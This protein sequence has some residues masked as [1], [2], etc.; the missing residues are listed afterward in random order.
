MNI[1][2]SI[3]SRTLV[4]WVLCTLIA[5][6]AVAGRYELIKRDVPGESYQYSDIP[7]GVCEAYEKN[8]NR[9]SDRPNGMAC[10]REIDPELGFTRPKWERLD[11]LKYKELAKDIGR[12]QG[13]CPKPP[14]GQSV[15]PKC[16][17]GVFARMI[18]NGFFLELTHLDI[19][20]DG[21]P[22]TVVRTGRD[23]PCDPNVESNF[24]HPPYESLYVADAGLTRVLD[25]SR[26]IDQ[27]GGDI[28]RYRGRVYSD[29]LFGGPYPDREGT[30]YLF[31]FGS[32]GPGE[33]CR[34]YYHDPKLKFTT[35]TSK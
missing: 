27:V 20:E 8:L 10:G 3:Y 30:L 1:F 9:F 18:E 26:F 13:S 35:E 12:F 24:R 23:W 34:L 33:I 25:A 19:N 31:R 21:N 7:G 15:D 29:M 32:H 16:L 5:T 6:P 17:D 11:P 22:D 4:A 14:A 2:V 28:F